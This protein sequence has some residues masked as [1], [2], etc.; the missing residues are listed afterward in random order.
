VTT[1]YPIEVPPALLSQ[2]ST[3]RAEW[4]KRCRERFGDCRFIT[5]DRDGA[6]ACWGPLSLEPLDTW[7]CTIEATGARMNSHV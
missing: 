6:V 4:E 3:A 5:R 2:I 1:P 7:T